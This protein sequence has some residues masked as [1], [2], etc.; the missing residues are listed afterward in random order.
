MSNNT[1]VCL[2][3]GNKIGYDTAECGRKLAQYIPY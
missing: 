1:S 2:F 3:D